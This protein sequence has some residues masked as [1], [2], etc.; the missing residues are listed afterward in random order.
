M[1]QEI[2]VEKAKTRREKP[3]LDNLGFGKDFTDHMFIMDY[4]KDKGWYNPRIVPYAPLQLDPATAVLHY[5]QSIFEGIKA[6]KSKDGR[7]LLFRPDKNFERMN[8][9]ND[10]MCIPLIDGD[11]CIEAIKKLI[12]I[13]KDW[14]PS[15]AGTSLYIRPFIFACD[16]YL[17]VR[18]SYTYK[19][20]V[21][22]SPVGSYYPQ[23]IKPVK[24]FVEDEYVRA[25][26]GG[27]GYVKTS[28]NYASSLKAQDKASKK[29]YV[30][31]L[32][33][34]GVEKKYV[35]EVG[36]MNVFFRI[37]DEVITPSLTGSILPGIT[38]DSSI[39]ILKSK[40]IKVVERK[41]TIDELYDAHSKGTLKEAF[42]TGTATV[43]A[44]IGELNW[45]DKKISIC[46]GQIGEISQ[47]LYDTL[48]GIQNGIV[49]DEFGWIHEVK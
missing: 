39:Q 47:M 3:D 48:T 17:G 25:V 16:P 20:M 49:E 2:S 7:I 34:D 5:G 38:R 30:Q 23:G 22:L 29:G 45:E 43:I 40:G 10:R 18:P 36:S 41:I 21:I 44:P 24:I 1:H 14:I 6:Y 33:L 12:L 42:G 26:I 8:K 9:S 13:E 46:N 4:N 37:D 32:W 35:E 11:F 27:T 19:Y 31:V 15:L 28:G